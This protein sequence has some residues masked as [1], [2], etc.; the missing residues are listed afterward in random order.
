MSILNEEWR[1]VSGFE[2]FYQVS[3]LGRVRSLDRVIKSCDGRSYSCKGQLLKPRLKKGYLCLHLSNKPRNYHVTVHRLVA[4]S[5]VDGYF[6][7]AQINHIDGVKTNNTPA[8]LEFCTSAHNVN[9]SIATG[10]R[11]NFG[12]KH[13]ACKLTED[14]VLEIRKLYSEGM[15]QTAIAKIYGLTIAAI[16][17][18]VHRKRWKDIA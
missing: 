5:F 10:L 1:D 13:W 8:N 11:D 7:G 4:L 17:K 15:T 6:E 16:G 9:H 3:N 18:V 12:V 14:Q 2:G